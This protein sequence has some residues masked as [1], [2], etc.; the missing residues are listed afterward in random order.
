MQG[1][2]EWLPVEDARPVLGA[3]QDTGLEQIDLWWT[4]ESVNSLADSDAKGIEVDEFIPS[5][6]AVQV[7]C[8]GQFAMVVVRLEELVSVKE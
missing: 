3:N 6:G 8:H 4:V 7:A 1:L 5:G 2:T